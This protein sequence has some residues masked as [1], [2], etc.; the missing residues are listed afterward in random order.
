MGIEMQNR[1]Q[2]AQETKAKKPSFRSILALLE[3]QGHL[4]ALSGIRLDIDN[5]ELDHK[6]PVAR[7]GTNDLS[8]LQWIHK[9]INR[10]K[11][12]MTNDE[13]IE[14]CAMVTNSRTAGPPMF[15]FLSE[16]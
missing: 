5:A 9:E 16:A 13:F 12:T 1:I 2:G 15:R 6:I 11:G 10:A 14:V 7:G 4:C 3:I 8:N